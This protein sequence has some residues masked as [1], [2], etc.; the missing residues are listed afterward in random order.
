MFRR[1]LVDWCSDFSETSTTVYVPTICKNPEA[2]KYHLSHSPF[3][4]SRGFPENVDGNRLIHEDTASGKRRAKEDFEARLSS[5]SA[6]SM[7][8]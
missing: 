1:I 2:V 7:W 5:E 8:C 4:K 6:C 3:Q